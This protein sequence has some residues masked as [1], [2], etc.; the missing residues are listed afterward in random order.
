MHYIP[1]YKR[2]IS[3]QKRHIRMNELEGQ[4]NS[5]TIGC[6]MGT[7]KTVFTISVFISRA[8]NICAPIRL[9]LSTA[10]TTFWVA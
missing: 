10:R 4:L 9:L 7:R 3:V 8:R 2:A 5:S 6:F 1:C